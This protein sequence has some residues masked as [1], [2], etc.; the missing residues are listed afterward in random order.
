MVKTRDACG[1]SRYDGCDGVGVMM[2]VPPSELFPLYQQF[3]VEEALSVMRHDLRNKL[4]SIRNAAFYVGRKLEKAAPDVA[5]KD[6]RVPQLLAL[7]GSEVQS[8]ESTVQ[9]RLLEAQGGE[10]LSAD[11]IL[12]RIH[13]LVALP[14]ALRVVVEVTGEPRV[15]VSIDE[16]AIALFCLIANGVDAMDGRDGTLCLRVRERDG[17]AALEVEDDGPGFAAGASERAFEPFFT[18]RPNRM[19]AGL[20]IARRIA[21]RWKGTVELASLERGTR[22]ALLLGVE[23]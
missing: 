3:V 1:C 12:R 19:G 5:T 21:T 13:A 14:K 10:V 20:K 23:S 6:P 22:A 18:T 2:V 7:I 4:G 17:R 11:A 16:A 8:A 9:S 15:R